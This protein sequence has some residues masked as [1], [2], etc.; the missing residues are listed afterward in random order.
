M[1]TQIPDVGVSN[2]LSFLKPS[3]FPNRVSKTFRDIGRNVVRDIKEDFY[4]DLLILDPDVIFEKYGDISEISSYLYYLHP[5][6]YIVWIYQTNP[7]LYK[8]LFVSLTKAGRDF[9][10]SCD[11]KIIGGLPLA[12]MLNNNHIRIIE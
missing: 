3:Q 10:A 7:V 11:E 1:A 4:T 2:I 9:F 8:M 6:E 5:R 12:W